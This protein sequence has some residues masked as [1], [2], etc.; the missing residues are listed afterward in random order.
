MRQ[1]RVCY[2]HLAG[3]FGVRMFDHMTQRKMLAFHSTEL[4]LTNLSPLPL[5]IEALLLD[6]STR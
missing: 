2:D 4:T 1:A 3:D 5:T 6:G